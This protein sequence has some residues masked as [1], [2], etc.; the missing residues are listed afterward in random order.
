MRIILPLLA[1]FLP[2]LLAQNNLTPQL[3]TSDIDNFWRAFDAGRPGNRA[4]AFQKL[5]FDVGSPGLRDFIT[6]RLTSAEELAKT[7]DEAPKFY[8]SIRKTTTQVAAQR[9]SVIRD[10]A[11][12]QE[13]RGNGD[14]HGAKDGSSWEN[15]K[16][17]E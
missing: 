1:T 14:R 3:V 4:D 13:P 9:E 15:F 7:V 12:F 8:A 6:S 16:A 2:G 17:A 11:R 5:Y 10:L